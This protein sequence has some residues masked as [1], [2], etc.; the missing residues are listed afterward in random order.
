MS[1]SFFF[2]SNKFFWKSNISFFI[3][4]VPD[5][6]GSQRSDNIYFKNFESIN[7]EFF[8][9]FQLRT[10]VR[11]ID[12]FM[13]CKTKN[14]NKMWCVSLQMSYYHIPYPLYRL[15]QIKIIVSPLWHLRFFV[16]V[17]FWFLD[18][19]FAILCRFFVA[20]LFRTLNVIDSVSISTIAISLFELVPC[21]SHLL[22]QKKKVISESGFVMINDLLNSI[23]VFI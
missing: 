15:Y 11:R 13:F 9:V 2:T 17:T 10:H 21:L 3:S 7:F 1:C 12:G 22:F 16:M 18:V 20:K 6:W 14:Y 23:I 8:L 19:W 5:Y 4:C